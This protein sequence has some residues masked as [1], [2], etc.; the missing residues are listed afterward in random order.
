MF[1]SFHV[2]YYVARQGD[3]L[4][5]FRPMQCSKYGLQQVCGK[6][7]F[8]PTGRRHIN[9]TGWR[10]DATVQLTP[11]CTMDTARA[12]QENGFVFATTKRSFSEFSDRFY[13]Q[14]RTDRVA[15]ANA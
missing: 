7:F 3:P 14:V 13:G 12:I 4:A 1:G 9:L 2:R 5:A 8:L 15:L 11:H 6:R 10:Y